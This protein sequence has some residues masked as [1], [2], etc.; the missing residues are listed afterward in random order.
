MANKEYVSAKPGVVLS[1]GAMV[2]VAR[3]THEWSQ[4]KLAALSGIPQPAIS[5]I[6]SGRETLG[7]ERAEKLARALRVHPSVLVWPNWETRPLAKSRT[8]TKGSKTAT[9]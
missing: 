9:R 3:E 6:E 5:A 8:S 7:I 2:R 4:A 1:P